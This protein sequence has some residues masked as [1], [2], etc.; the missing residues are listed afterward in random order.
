MEKELRFEKTR[1]TNE[2]VTAKIT[3]LIL[4]KSHGI[5]KTMTSSGIKAEAS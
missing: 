2:N 1:E 5:V 4:L 3:D